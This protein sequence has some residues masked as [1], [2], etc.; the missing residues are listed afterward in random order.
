MLQRFNVPKQITVVGIVMLLLCWLPP[1][2]AAGGLQIQVYA[3]VKPSLYPNSILVL[4]EKEAVLIDGQWWTSEGRKVAELLQQSGRR[5]TT[6]LITHAH[7][8]HYMGLNPVLERFPG[9]RVLVRQALHDEIQY[10]FPSKRRHWQELVPDDMPLQPVPTEVFNGDSI[11][12]EGHEI[13]FIDLPPAETLHATA[14]YIPDARALVTGDL[15][16]A[17]S[18]A[19]FAD[20]DNP[21]SWLHALDVV[22][23]AGP[24]DTVYPGHGPTG[25]PE[26]LDAMADYVRTY[27]DIA[28][29][30]VR[31]AVIARAM[32]QRYPDYDGALLLWLTR[33]PGFALYGAREMG[34]PAELIPGPPPGQ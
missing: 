34:V 8:D 6:V 18:H 23:R 21:D 1:A 28:R 22:R 7:P 11:R 25:G 10:S 9:A 26:L 4:G 5:L 30:G 2:A 29:P 20:V 12:L 32:M 16:F 31:V 15:V 19:Y 3:G 14:F 13:R 17:H 33:G 24:I 27:R